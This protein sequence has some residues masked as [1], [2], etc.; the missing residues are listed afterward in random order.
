MSALGAKQTSFEGLL[1]GFSQA[2]GQYSWLVGLNRIS[3]T[4]TSSG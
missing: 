4:S 3:F 2:L 1:Y